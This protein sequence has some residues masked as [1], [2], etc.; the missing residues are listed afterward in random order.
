MFRFLHLLV[1][2]SGPFRQSY[3]LDVSGGLVGIAGRDGAGKTTIA[4]ALLGLLPEATPQVAGTRVQAF[5]IWLMELSEGADLPYG[6]KSWPLLGDM[7][8]TRRLPADQLLSLQQMVAR[9]LGLITRQKALAY[10]AYPDRPSPFLDLNVVIDQSGRVNISNRASGADLNWGFQAMGERVALQLATALAMREQLAT[11]ELDVPFVAD[12]V[13]DM[14]DRFL[15]IGA[16]TLLCS[17]VPQ[18]IVLDREDVLDFLGVPVRY[19]L[20]WSDDERGSEV[21]RG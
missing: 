15:R 17:R 20:A 1:G 14:L 9:N 21:R 13:F 7:L 6:G 18:L 12:S 8:S 2:P 19:R 5:P 11:E 16:L 4:R 10:S 3:E